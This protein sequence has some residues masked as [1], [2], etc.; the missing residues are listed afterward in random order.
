MPK[1]QPDRVAMMLLASSASLTA[2]ALAAPPSECPPN[3]N[4]GSIYY[5]DHLH[6]GG[7]QSSDVVGGK[8]VPGEGWQVVSFGDRIVHDFGDL[9]DSGTLSVWIRGL[10]V[11][12]S[13]TADNH[14]LF[15]LKNAFD[16]PDVRADWG[17]LRVYGPVGG[18]D[19]AGDLKL[20]FGSVEPNGCDGYHWNKNALS[21]DPNVWYHVELEFD[22]QKSVLRIQ[23][24]EMAWVDNSG[25][26]CQTTLRRVLM[27]CKKFVKGAIDP[28]YGAIYA[29]LSF[30]GHKAPAC[31]EPCSDANDCTIGDHCTGTECVGTP[32]PDGTACDDHDAATSNTVCSFGS[33]IAKCSLPN[34]GGILV[35]QDHT[36]SAL[37]PDKHYSDVTS[38]D[39]EQNDGTGAPEAVSYLRFE[40][41]PVP[42]QKI[43]GATLHLYC[44]L[45][46]LPAAA[47]GNGGDLHLVPDNSWQ[48]GSIT[49]NNK[50]KWDDAVI[51]S[52]GKIALDQWYTFDVSSAIKASGTYSFAIVPNA[53]NGGHYLS[54]EG[55]ADGCFQP[56]LT[57]ETVA[58][59]DA[60]VGGA[61]AGGVGGGNAGGSG[62]AAG[63]QGGVVANEDDGCGCR[64]AGAPAVP[65]S[66]WL[67]VLALLGVG[68]GC[69]RP[70]RGRR[71][72]S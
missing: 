71:A 56:H 72:C 19:I 11:G 31:A 5:C 54:K 42:G 66:H 51:A 13:F 21:W 40:V 7:T 33:C 46:S 32:A 9:A 47:D 43:V 30:I 57:L 25:K 59:P 34:A 38:L 41:P 45:L 17:V 50:P 18:S 49:W 27:P 68:F 12:S 4:D 61:G 15:E 35:A 3:P 20:S 2:P 16:W 23:G 10:G 1:W 63:A 52:Q 62:G 65:N 55:G 26:G 14:H 37:A 28:P 58:S 67:S 8:F 36:T 39:V 53:A 44:G 48:E 70:C 29:D 64:V 60:G 69:R 22:S 24:K 6:S